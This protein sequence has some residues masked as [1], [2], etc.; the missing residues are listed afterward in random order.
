[1]R[2]NW[3]A[4][5]LSALSDPILSALS[6][7]AQVQVWNAPFPNPLSPPWEEIHKGDLNI[8]LLDPQVPSASQQWILEISKLCPGLTITSPTE[9]EYAGIAL[10]IETHLLAQTCE[11]LVQNRGKAFERQITHEAEDVLYRFTPQNWGLLDWE[12]FR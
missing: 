2:I 8:Y 11:L 6:S 7:R 5:P 10:E 9:G 4:S 1:M 3:F 12:L